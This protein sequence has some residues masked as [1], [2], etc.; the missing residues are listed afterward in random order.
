MQW[1][2]QPSGCLVKSSPTV[3][4]QRNGLQA[5]VID[6]D[7]VGAVLPRYFVVSAIAVELLPQRDLSSSF[8]P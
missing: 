4:A 6:F 3:R 7:Y 8:F 1:S 2:F 5:Q